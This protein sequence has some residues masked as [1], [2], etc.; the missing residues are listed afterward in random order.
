MRLYQNATKTAEIGF[1]S[2]AAEGAGGSRQ[3]LRHGN[4][5]RLRGNFVVGVHF[6]RSNVNPDYSADRTNCAIPIAAYL[7]NPMRTY[8]LPEF[9]T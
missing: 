7:Q 1:S 9:F 5:I 6:V 2:P 4:G 3:R 8:F